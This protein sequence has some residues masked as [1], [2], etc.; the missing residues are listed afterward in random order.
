MCGVAGL[1]MSRHACGCPLF[2]LTPEVATQRKLALYR[3]G[4]SFYLGQS[5]DRDEVRRAAEHELLQRGE[6]KQGDLIVMTIG[7][8]MGKSG[9]TN[10]MQIV[11]VGEPHACPSHGHRPPA[12]PAP[13]PGRSA[14]RDPAR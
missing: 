12:P 10:T 11:K 4:R 14:P 9:G 2:A 7:E 13:R 6:V 3:N 8:P 1:W 5:T